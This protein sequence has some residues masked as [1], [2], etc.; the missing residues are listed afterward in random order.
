MSEYDQL[1]ERI[2]K[3]EI[4]EAKQAEKIEQLEEE[5]LNLRKGISRGLWAVGGSALTTMVVAF[6]TWILSWLN[7]NLN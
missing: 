7:I 4:E 3:L 5:V 2:H 1:L 6:V